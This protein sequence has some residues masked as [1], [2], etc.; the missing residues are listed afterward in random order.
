M[1]DSL[2][3]RKRV[4][5]PFIDTFLQYLMW[6]F[7]NFILN[8]T[9]INSP[10]NSWWWWKDLSHFSFFLFIVLYKFS[11]LVMKTRKLKCRGMQAK[12]KP[13]CSYFISLW[14]IAFYQS[15][16]FSLCFATSL[17]FDKMRWL[18]SNSFLSFSVSPPCSSGIIHGN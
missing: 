12:R 2:G 9:G 7:K 11:L 14:L 18:S 10:P 17:V 3:Y 8:L 13:L 15:V 4:L 16:L 5:A 1:E 6:N